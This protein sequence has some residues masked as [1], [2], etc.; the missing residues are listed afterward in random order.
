MANWR[1]A[2]VPFYL[3]S[4]KRLATHASEIVVQFRQVP[5]SMFPGVEPID[6]EPAGAAA[7]ARRGRAPATW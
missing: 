4:G 5:H 7:A 2:G 3:R 1:W 6:A